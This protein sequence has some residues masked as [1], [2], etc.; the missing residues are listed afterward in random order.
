MRY[1]NP[2]RRA[3]LALILT[4]AVGAIAVT[5][6][7]A[8][9]AQDDERRAWTMWLA[10]K[11]TGF[12]GAVLIGRGDDILVA[13]ASGDADRDS[14]RKNPDASRFNL[15][16]INKTFTA[17][18]IAQLIQQNRLSLDDTLA[19]R[20]PDYPNREAA[21]RITIRDLIAHRS[22]VPVFMMASF[23]DV[24]VA[25]MVKIVAAQPQS[26]EPGTRQEYSNGG[27]I[28]LGRLC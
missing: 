20:L 28:L 22:G 1:I 7:P 11:L 4:S 19:K 13:R 15:G 3:A 23:G 2:R 16:S 24:S 5:A 12:S 25:D 18:A 10:A 9:Q 17:M 8:F 6:A 27:Y 21:A 26:F 14:G